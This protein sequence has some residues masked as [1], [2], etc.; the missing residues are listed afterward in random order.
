VSGSVRGPTRRH[1]RRHGR[2]CIGGHCRREPRRGDAELRVV[3]ARADERHARAVRVCAGRGRVRRAPPPE[4]TLVT[5][6]RLA[7]PGEKDDRDPIAAWGDHERNDRCGRWCTW[8]ATKITASFGHQQISMKLRLVHECSFLDQNEEQEQT[9]FLVTGPA[10]F[11]YQIGSGADI[12]LS[13]ALPISH[14]EM[15]RN[16]VTV[17]HAPRVQRGGSAQRAS[18][19]PH[20]HT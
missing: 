5:G 11:T 8:F 13:L 20:Q 18:R 19:A 17:R 2:A 1:D 14:A 4:G 12:S 10:L 9:S 7:W 3:G 15:P 6:P 16:R